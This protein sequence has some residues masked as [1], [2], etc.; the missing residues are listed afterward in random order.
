MPPPRA[1]RRGR[2]PPLMLLLAALMIIGL[3]SVSHQKVPG[4]S[5]L[6]SCIPMILCG[7]RGSNASSHEPLTWLPMG[8]QSTV[9]AAAHGCLCV[10]T[11]YGCKTLCTW[12]LC[13]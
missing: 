6:G 1:A 2:L 8:H 5:R 9:A 12:A 3:A 11:S 10:M 4:L 13:R 7:R